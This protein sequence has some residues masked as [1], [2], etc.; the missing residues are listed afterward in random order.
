MG[1]GRRLE[2]LGAKDG[3]NVYYDYAHHPTEIRESINA[4]R[5][6]EGGNIT[7]IFKPHTYSR[8]KALFSELCEAL[9]LADSVLL[10]DIS[11]IREEYDPTVSSSLLA[12]KIGAHS[13][14][15]EENE[16]LDNIPKDSGT[17]VIM[18]AA[19]LS[20]IKEII[21]NNKCGYP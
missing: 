4:I 10:L 2:R 1:V 8:T 3:R 18:G 21:E 14:K 11:A 19:D 6:R 7:V 15:I 17:V 12:E 9:S 20:K 13:R 16:V 5:E